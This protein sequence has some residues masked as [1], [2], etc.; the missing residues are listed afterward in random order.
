MSSQEETMRNEMLLCSFILK[1]IFI[2]GE[3]KVDQKYFEG[4]QFT[5]YKR[6]VKKGILKS[7]E[8]TGQS[9]TNFTN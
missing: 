6:I 5:I 1:C 3:S 2:E 4:Q 8:Y 9:L 7:L